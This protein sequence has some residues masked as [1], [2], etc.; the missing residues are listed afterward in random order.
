MKNLHLK[1]NGCV[2]YLLCKQVW[3]IMLYP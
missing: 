2:N 3:F 1:E